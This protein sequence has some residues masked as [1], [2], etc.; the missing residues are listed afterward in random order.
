MRAVVTR[1]QELMHVRGGK[2]QFVV[3]R[4]LLVDLA[5]RD[6]LRSPVES[7]RAPYVLRAGMVCTRP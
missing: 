4:T 7:R 2:Q 5:V 6:G 3:L 1:M